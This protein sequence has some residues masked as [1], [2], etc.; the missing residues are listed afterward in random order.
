MAEKCN[1]NNH[2]CD[3]K[4]SAST[5]RAQHVLIEMD[6]V[7]ESYGAHRLRKHCQI[8][9]ETQVDRCQHTSCARECDSPEDAITYTD[10]HDSY[11]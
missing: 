1:D 4:H 10:V 7:S 11:V 5:F 8:G 2:K 6:E 9:L 3:G